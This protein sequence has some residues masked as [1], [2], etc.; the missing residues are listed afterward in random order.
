MKGEGKYGGAGTWELSSGFTMRG[1][2]STSS[3]FRDLFKERL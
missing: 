2:T 3:S 1:V